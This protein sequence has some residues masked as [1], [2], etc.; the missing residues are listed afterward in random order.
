MSDKND[1]KILR[2]LA[3][4]KA[5][6]ATL[7]VN[8]ENKKLWT[9]VNDMKETKAA[10]YIDEIPWHEMGYNEELTLKTK[11]SFHKNIERNL[12]QEIY[13][14]KHMRGNMIVE[15]TIYCPIV[16]NDSGFGIEEISDIIAIDKNSTTP[17][18]HFQVQIKDVED[19]ERIKNPVV[20]VDEKQ[21][22][23]NY[24][25]LKA[26]F[27]GIL[28]VQKSGVK[29]MWFTPWDNL[30]RWTGVTEALMDL[31]LQPEYIEKLVSRF[32]D[33]SLIRLE[34]YEKLGLWSSNND[35]TRVGSG[36]YGYC[37]DLDHAEKYR[38]NAP[39]SQLWGCGNAQIFS[40][41]SPQMHWDF[42]LKYEIRWLERF[43]LNYYG[44][45]E[46]LSGKFDIL[47]KIPN[48]RKVSMSPWANLDVACE[49]AKNKYILS[50]KPNPSIFATTN[51]NKEQA[52]KEIQEILQ[53]TK[54]CNIEII[55]KDISTVRFD[56]QR[57]WEWAK[58]A[59][60]TVNDFYGE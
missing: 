57:L 59:Q 53:K 40:E 6:I 8:E 23:E 18:R 15:P 48:L 7:S 33:A 55:M 30:V 3:K 11:D 38:E 43:G 16:I 25:R 37:S 47:G 20:S 28:K 27:N 10:I 60:E 35:N 14:W 12:R 36:G 58:I 4:I 24:Q 21:T 49:R 13:C 29:G 51:F 44:C 45:C 54:G 32:V 42:S 5:E 17:S 2:E 56:P 39:L 52:K 22:E 19:I 9:N 1:I 31:I 34:Q 41:V 46:P 26:I 50:C